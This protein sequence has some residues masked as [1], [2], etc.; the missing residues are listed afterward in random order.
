MAGLDGAE[1]ARYARHL[2]LPEVGGAGQ[3]RLKA[4]RVLIVGAG[5]LGSPALLYLAAAGIGTLGIADDDTVALSNLQRQIAHATADIDLAKTASAADAVARL[6]PHVAV[7]EH[8]VRVDADNV[9]PLVAEYDVVLDGSDNFATRYLLA[10]A[11]EAA[12]RPLV[13]AALG[14]FDGSLTTLM[15]Y[16][17]GPDGRLNPRLTDLFPEAPPPGTVPSCAEAGI[18]GAV[19][20]VIGTLQATEALR[21]LLDL[22]APMVGR[23][24]L[25]DLL[26]MRFD[27]IAYQRRA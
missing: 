15:P 17:S 9:G 4:A 7:R 6:N 21:V 24:L 8:R 23:L 14:R 26:S 2:V 16:A 19:A 27:E 11:C 3:Q 20:G 12:Q 1:I 13:V 10:A 22:G 25:V 18:L 5:G